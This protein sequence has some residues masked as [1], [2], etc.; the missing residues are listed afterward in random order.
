MGNEQPKEQQ[1][2]LV[3][4]N[5]RWQLAFWIITIICGTF[6]VGLTSAV[7][8]NDRLRSEG[9]SKLRDKIEYLVDKNHQQFMT[10][11]GELREIKVL[12]SERTGA[13]NNPSR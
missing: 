12:I 6:F 9:D 8:A 3:N 1:R 11:S 4:G 2:V 10:I 13:I 5:G 7:V